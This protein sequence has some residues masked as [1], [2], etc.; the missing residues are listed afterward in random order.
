MPEIWL[1][2]AMIESACLA[3]NARPRGEPPAWTKAPRRG[4]LHQQLHDLTCAD[5]FRR[6]RGGGPAA[7]PAAALARSSA[8]AACPSVHPDRG[9]RGGARSNALLR[10]EQTDQKPQLTR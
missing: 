8:D 5:R 9:H 4:V 6:F 3:A 7:A 2:V 1:A 10:L